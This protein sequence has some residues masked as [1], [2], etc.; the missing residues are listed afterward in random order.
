MDRRSGECLPPSMSTSDSTDAT[1]GSDSTSEET[2]TTSEE[3]RRAWD[4]AS[5]KHV[6]EYASLLAEARIAR[7]LPSE[8]RL[9]AGLV[10]DAEVIHPQSGHGIDDHALLRL[11]A[12]SVLGVDYSPTAVTA[13]QRGVDDLA[14]PARYVVA[15]PPMLRG[16]ERTAATSRGVTSTTRS[17]GVG[18]PSISAPSPRP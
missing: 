16:C 10:E 2:R 8:E 15:E 12:A 17:P 1:G 6:R 9:L 14:F 5:H 18:R 11:G 4:D 7:L 13:A 3:T